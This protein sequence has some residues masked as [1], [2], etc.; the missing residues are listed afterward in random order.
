M[1]GHTTHRWW[2]VSEETS[3][4]ASKVR[5]SVKADGIN[6]HNVGLESTN[7]RIITQRHVLYKLS[8][9]FPK[10]L[11]SALNR[12]VKSALIV[13]KF[14]MHNLFILLDEKI[15]KTHKRQHLDK[16]NGY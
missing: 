9:H 10:I 6:L 7:A 8:Q 11:K 12:Q 13:D 4:L 15:D 5:C 16:N 2:V 1:A 3:P 14:C